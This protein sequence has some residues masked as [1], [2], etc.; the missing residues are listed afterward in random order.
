MVPESPPL[1]QARIK[2][3]RPFEVT[4]VDFTGALYVRNHG[5]DSKVY[6]CLFMCGLS[7]AVHLQVVTDLSMEMFLQAFHRFTSRRS[8]PYLMLSDNASTYVLAAK[9]LE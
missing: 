1:P 4:G 5:I 2:E 8:L 3:G 7:R 9:E 6:I